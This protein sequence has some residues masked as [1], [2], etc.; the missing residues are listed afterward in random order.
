MLIKYI[1]PGFAWAIFILVLCGMPLKDTGEISYLDKVFHFGVFAILSLVLMTG[2]KRQY[3][4]NK[5]RYY[6]YLAAI[7]I[8][9][10]YGALIELSQIVFFNG[11]EGEWLDL[12]ANSLGAIFGYGLF[13]IIYGNT[14][15]KTS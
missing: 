5:L 2:F 7:I 13:K 12:L 15:I 3:Y 8:S 1:L 6:A 14:R 10:L 4:S 11:R 9:I